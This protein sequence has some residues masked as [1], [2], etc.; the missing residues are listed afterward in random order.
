VKLSIISNNNIVCTDLDGNLNRLYIQWRWNQIG[1]SNWLQ[2]V[3]Y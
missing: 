1:L 2:K 3:L